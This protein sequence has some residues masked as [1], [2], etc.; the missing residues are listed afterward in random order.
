[1]VAG[2]SD[3]IFC[4]SAGI[5]TSVPS[6]SVRVIGKAGAAVGDGGARVGAVAVVAGAAVDGAVVPVAA[7]V[8]P[9]RTR[10]SA[11]NR[12]AERRIRGAAMEVSAVV[13]VGRGARTGA[14]ADGGGLPRGIASRCL[15][16]LSKVEQ[17]CGSATGLPSRSDR[18]MVTVA[19]LCRIHTGFAAL[20]RVV[21]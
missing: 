3:T 11:P 21:A 17:H 15:P 1:M 14:A 16:F 10:A 12:R 13:G 9:A 8:Q 7:G 20:Q 5:V 18:A 2:V 6:S 4:G 19:G